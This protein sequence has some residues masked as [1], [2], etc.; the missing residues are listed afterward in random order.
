MRNP[1]QVTA[2]ARVVMPRASLR[3]IRGGSK[4][5]NVTG[6]RVV[7]PRAS[8]RHNYPVDSYCSDKCARGDATRLIETCYTNS[9]RKLPLKVRAW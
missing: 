8:L 7:M 3:L 2:R 9:S 4:K 6:A 5:R 1:L